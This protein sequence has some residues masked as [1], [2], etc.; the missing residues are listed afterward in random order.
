MDETKNENL[1]ET[2]LTPAQIANSSWR[3][4]LHAGGKHEHIL[5]DEFKYAWHSAVL[6][7]DA[8]FQELV[9]RGAGWPI[10]QFKGLIPTDIGD[11]IA[12]EAALKHMCQLYNGEDDY[13]DPD[14]QL[15]MESSWA[16]WATNKRKARQS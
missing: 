14:V 13:R 7:M 15:A 1:I 3:A 4:Y 6:Q 5:T 10:S 8:V 16:E 11:D 9:E 12:V 2:G